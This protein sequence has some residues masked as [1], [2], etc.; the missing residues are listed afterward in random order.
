M[1]PPIYF[2]VERAR[3]QLLQEGKVYTIRYPRQK[4]ITMAR[5]GSYFR[6]KMLG[7]VRITEVMMLDLEY[8]KLQGTKA[9]LQKYVTQSGFETVDVWLENFKRQE[10][11]L[12]EIL[13]FVEALK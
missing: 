4:G 1:I 11:H 13:Y 10:N 3:N 8:E 5:H 7:K 6:F 12:N 2:N 9:V